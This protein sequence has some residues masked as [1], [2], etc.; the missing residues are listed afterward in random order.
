MIDGDSIFTQTGAVR[1]G[2]S[3]GLS[4]RNEIRNRQRCISHPLA[5]GKERRS[6][7]SLVCQIHHTI[8]V[9]GFDT[10]DERTQTYARIRD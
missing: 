5:I 8:N 10:A 7:R 3:F 2:C 6:V 1:V 9:F 4:V